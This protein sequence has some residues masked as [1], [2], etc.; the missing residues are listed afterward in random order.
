MQVRPIP[1]ASGRTFLEDLFDLCRF[2]GLLLQSGIIWI[3]LGGYS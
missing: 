2:E 1:T 3:S